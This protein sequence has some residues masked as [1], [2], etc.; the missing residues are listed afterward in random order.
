MSSIEEYGAKLYAANRGLEAERDALRAFV[1]DLFEATD[2]PDGN[3]L[4]GFQFQE[5]ATKHGI[6]TPEERIAPC[7]GRE[8][9]W[10]SDFGGPGQVTCYRKAQ[11]LVDAQIALAALDKEQK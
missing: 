7:E 4:D 9:C 11:W 10:C 6:L 8:S 1:A 3:D 5:L 2:W